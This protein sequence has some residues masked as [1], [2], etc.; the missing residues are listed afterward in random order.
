MEVMKKYGWKEVTEAEFNNYFI[1]SDYQYSSPDGYTDF[2]EIELPQSKT[3]VGAI[4]EIDKKNHYFYK[5][6]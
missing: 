2:Y 1:S 3:F 6:K 4:K 5:L